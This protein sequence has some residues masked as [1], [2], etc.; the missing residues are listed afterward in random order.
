MLLSSSI[1]GHD[2]QGLPGLDEELS[3]DALG[4]AVAELPDFVMHMSGVQS[5][6]SPL[7]DPVET[8]SLSFV[9]PFHSLAR[10]DLS[11]SEALA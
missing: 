4:R 5:I 11:L 10:L 6:P 2:F 3:D 8:V 7:E 1:S 9:M